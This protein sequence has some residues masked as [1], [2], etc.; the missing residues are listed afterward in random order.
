MPTITEVS[1]EED[2]NPGLTEIQV[3]LDSEDVSDTRSGVNVRPGVRG[4]D[5][6]WVVI[7]TRFEGT[8]ESLL[9]EGDDGSRCRPSSLKSLPLRD[10]QIGP[11]CNAALP[12]YGGSQA[13]EASNANQTQN[14]P[15]GHSNYSLINR[16]DTVKKGRSPPPSLQSSHSPATLRESAF[17]RYPG[18]SE[19][20]P[21][22]TCA[23]MLQH[24][25]IGTTTEQKSSF[26][27][28]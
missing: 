28:T 12:E 13:P 3:C 5:R 9:P 22:K 25:S 24:S 16:T 14:Q 7:S 4:P 15:G 26:I 17:S 23:E 19:I 20:R 27:V 2:E 10:F 8:L 21:A 6:T 11:K 18:R 1:D